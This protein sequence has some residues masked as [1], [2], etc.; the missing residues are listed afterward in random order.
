MLK[1]TVTITGGNPHRSIEMSM[2]E[3]IRFIREQATLLGDISEEEPICLVGFDK[4]SGCDCEFVSKIDG[5][6]DLHMD[7]DYED[8]R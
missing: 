2:E 4:S 5:L 3:Y 8:R 1:A 6:C 7:P